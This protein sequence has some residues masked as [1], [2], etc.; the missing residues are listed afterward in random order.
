MAHRLASIWYP[1]PGSPPSQGRAAR[2]ELPTLRVD[3]LKAWL[4][5]QGKPISG[6]KAELVARI[7]NA[8]G[9]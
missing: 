2:G 6:N 8:L 5:S 1:T 9:L 7:N 4:R 3:D